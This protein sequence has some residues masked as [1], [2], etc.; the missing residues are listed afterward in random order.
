MLWRVYSALTDCCVAGIDSMVV[1]RLLRRLAPK[2]GNYRVVGIHV[3][4]A[5]R[6]ESSAEATSR[7]KQGWAHSLI[8]VV[9]A[10]GGFCAALVRGGGD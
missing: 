2:H 6:D 8:R 10:T 7:H 3:D 5:N 1:A 4:Y 9:L